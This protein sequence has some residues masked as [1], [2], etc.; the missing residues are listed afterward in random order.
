MRS[1]VL[2]L[3]AAPLA[4]A[5]TLQDA[6]VGR[7]AVGVEVQQSG[8]S[9]GKSNVGG[10]STSITE[11]IIIWVNNGGNSQTSTMNSA[12]AVA[13]TAAASMQTHTVSYP[14]EEECRD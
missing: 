6:L 11:V 8:G 12:M 4:L 10:S 3:C 7:Q 1:S 2:A 14:T 5:G 13:G 9:S